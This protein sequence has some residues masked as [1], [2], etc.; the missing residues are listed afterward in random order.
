MANDRNAGRKKKFNVPTKKIL[1]PVVIEQEVKEL[2]KPYLNK[3]G[4]R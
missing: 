2:S 3:N 4:K 1:I